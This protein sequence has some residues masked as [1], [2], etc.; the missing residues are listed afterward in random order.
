MNT[1]DRIFGAGPRGLLI[2]LVLLALAW[3]LEPVA[4]LLNIT[5]SHTVRW[6][7][8]V[9][10]TVGAIAVV[11]WSTRS[12]SVTARGKELV[13][14]GAFRYIRHPLYAAF[15]SCFN[16]GLAVLLNNW[17]YII[18]AIL[19]HVVWHWN[20]QS[21][22]KLMKQEFPGSYEKYC[23]VTGRFVPRIGVTRHNTNKGSDQIV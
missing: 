16:F 5:A 15:L 20:I 21:E 8:F 7:V 6:V 4:G 10:T 22:E 3:Q 14:T 19:L 11:I 17:I 18:W 2:S 23:Q 1:Y 13:I 9:L 12:L